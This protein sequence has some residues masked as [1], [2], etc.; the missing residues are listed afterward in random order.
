MKKSI[1]TL[2]SALLV[3][4]IANPLAAQDDITVPLSKP[5]Q[6]GMLRIDL[7]YADDIVVKTH[8]RQD[9]IVQYEGED[10]KDDWNNRKDGLR[11]ISSGGLSLEIT[12]DN[13]V[14][15]I[16]SQPQHN[17]LELIVLVPKNFSLKLNAVHGD[18]AVDGL[19]GQVEIESV[20]G[21]VEV[22]NISGSAL[23]NSVNGD[24]E[25]SFTKTDPN[26]PM[27][28]T[29]VNGDIEVSFPENAKFTAKMKTDWGDVYTNFD[30]EIDRSPTDTQ[31]SS[32]KGQ[33]KV[34]INK[35]VNGTVNGGGPEYL[36][37][38]LHGDIS[39][40]KNK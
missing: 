32:K 18:V 15:K 26:A 9:V 28:F 23:V 39:I 24:I 10:D 3:L 11:R 29:G 31:V 2:F 22:F 36:F 12:E 8:N 7:V 1:I 16:S 38:T 4:G 5:G 13:N 37:K 33:Y 34:S 14:V 25:V 40:R 17:D 30:M 21:D 20:N 6:K 19:E 35:W 27:S